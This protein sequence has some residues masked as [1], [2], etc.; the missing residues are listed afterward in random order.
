MVVR[1]GHHVRSSG[2][3]VL[4]LVVLLLLVCVEKCRHYEG[5]YR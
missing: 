3:V 2:V 4:L 1:V 5:I